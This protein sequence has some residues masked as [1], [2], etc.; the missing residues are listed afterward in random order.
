MHK[1]HE[2]STSEIR[3]LSLAGL[4]GRNDR[5][6]IVRAAVSKDRHLIFFRSYCCQA[7]ERTAS[8]LF[9]FVTRRFFRAKGM[10]A[11]NPGA[12]VQERSFHKPHAPKRWDCKARLRFRS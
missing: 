10:I 7:S 2:L 11:G 12:R 5:F 4:E 8:A 3:V 6:G 1:D 9:R